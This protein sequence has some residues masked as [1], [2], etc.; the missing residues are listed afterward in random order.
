MT[1]QH[2]LERRATLLGQRMR[3]LSTTLAQQLG[4]GDRPVFTTPMTKAE[5]LA[6]WGEHRHDTYGQKVLETMQPWDI[7]Q[8]DAD[9]GA[10]RDPTQAGTHI[11]D[12]VA[13]ALAELD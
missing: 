11:T 8:L 4:A 3:E 9:L 10:L 12:G 7:A 13:A 2:R 1:T 5:S 6:W